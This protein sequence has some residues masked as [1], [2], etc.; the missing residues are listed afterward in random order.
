V[1]GTHDKWTFLFMTMCKRERVGDECDNDDDHDEIKLYSFAVIVVIYDI[2]D[3]RRAPEII[4]IFSCSVCLRCSPR[5][6][7]RES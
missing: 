7:D 5:F 6:V 2:C 4:C 3:S 1:R